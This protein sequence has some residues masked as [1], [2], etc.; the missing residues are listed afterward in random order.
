MTFEQAQI[1][2]LHYL[3]HLLRSS[4]LGLDKELTH[5]FSKDGSQTGF[6]LLSAGIEMMSIISQIFAKIMRY[7][8]GE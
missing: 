7:R 5:S 2:P 4:D 3:T 1:Y 8:D 6:D